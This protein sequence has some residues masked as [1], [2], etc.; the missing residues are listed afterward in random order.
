MAILVPD[1]KLNFFGLL[2]S[3]FVRSKNGLVLYLRP[4]PPSRS[5]G[6]SLAEGASWMPLKGTQA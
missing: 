5:D 4:V 1:D 2:E 6:S 3:F